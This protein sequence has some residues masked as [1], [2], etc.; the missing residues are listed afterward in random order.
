MFSV[1]PHGQEY[2]RLRKWLKDARGESG[3]STRALA[4]ILGV[5][6]SIVGKVE[7]GDRKLEVFELIN[8]CAAMG[9]P[10]EE[11]FEAALK[12]SE[13]VKRR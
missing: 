13:P 5:H 4:E 11:G 12:A 6:H 7:S 9:V 2:D 1:S 3:L 10:A 8:Y